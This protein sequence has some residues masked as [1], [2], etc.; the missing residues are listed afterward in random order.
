MSD[1]K[2]LP[3]TISYVFAHTAKAHRQR[4]EDLLNKIGLHTG[5]EMML[6]ILWDNEGITQS[7]LAERLGIQPAT[8]TNALNRL[9]RNGLVERRAD[10][11]DQRVS[12]V[13][14]TA[15]GKDIRL[16]IESQWAELEQVTLAGLS[17]EECEQ[18][19]SLL[20]KVQANLAG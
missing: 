18:L 9:E 8:V 2:P 15:G 11:T 4:A 13:F 20:G 3:D 19:L 17:D 12:R 1:I 6:C 5:Q 7:E 10:E 16:A 14:P